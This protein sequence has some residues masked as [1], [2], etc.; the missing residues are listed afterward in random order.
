MLKV[1]V[2]FN[3]IFI[4]S[5]ITIIKLSITIL[6][7]SLLYYILLAILVLIIAHT[8]LY[9]GPNPNSTSRHLLIY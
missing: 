9:F 3:Y 1:I 6:I 8:L 5:L 7:V 2:V 4:V